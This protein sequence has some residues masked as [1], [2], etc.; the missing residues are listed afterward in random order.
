MHLAVPKH[1][2]LVLILNFSDQCCHSIGCTHN[3]NCYNYMDLFY[4]V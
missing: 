3:S 1:D 2:V 4:L